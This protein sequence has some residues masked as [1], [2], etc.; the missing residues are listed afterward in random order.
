MEWPLRRPAVPVSKTPTWSSYYLAACPTPSDPT[1][2][3]GT[4]VPT[5]GLEAYLKRVNANS[6][7]LVLPAHVLVRAVGYCL[8]KHPD[9]NRRVLHRRLYDFKQVNILFPLLGKNRGPEVCLLCDVDRK[10]LAELAA[11]IW[12]HWREIT[13]G[14]SRYQRDERIFRLMPSLLRGMLF[15]LMLFGVNWVY[16]PA[17]LWGHR[18]SRASTMVNYLG[19]R[20]APPMRTFK[21]SRFPN[22][23]ATLNVTMGPTEHGD[24][25][26]PA[27]SLFVR[28]DHRVV[29]AYQL[30]QFVGDLRRCLMD[31]AIMERPEAKAN[32]VPEAGAA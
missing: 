16:Q 10:P 12:Q 23:A 29:D 4:D 25:N 1:M 15:R 17:A 26:G 28:A 13:K 2:V 19:Q 3:W 22:D 5:S 6:R 14:N 32:G 18:T 27:A 11:E 9:F 21:P 20:G 30:G 8:D 7:A 24:P 31:P